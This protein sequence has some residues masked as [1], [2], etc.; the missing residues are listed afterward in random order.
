MAL[1]RNAEIVRDDWFLLADD[2][3][4]P[5][6]GDIVVGLARLEREHGALAAH[7]GRLGVYL[8]NTCDAAR[9][10]PHVARLDLVVL[11]FPTFTDGRAYSQARLLRRELGYPGELRAS[12]DVLPDQLLFMLRVGIDSFEIDDMA[13]T[14]KQWRRPARALSH[15]YQRGYD[16]P[17]LKAREARRAGAEP[18]RAISANGAADRRQAT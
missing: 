18:D 11:D 3:R 8:P 9:L 10:A 16:L 15:A 12:G 14:S 17:G 1:V 4:Q 5:D 7:P 2:N 6:A 13:A